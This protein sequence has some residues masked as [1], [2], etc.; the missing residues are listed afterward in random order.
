MVFNFGECFACRQ[1]YGVSTKIHLNFGVGFG[2]RV[3]CVSKSRANDAL[4]ISRLCVFY[5][6]R[7]RSAKY[8]T[9]H[10]K[11]PRCEINTN[12][13]VYF[14]QYTFV[15]AFT[16]TMNFIYSHFSLAFSFPLVRFLAL[17]LLL[18]LTATHTQ[19]HAAIQILLLLFFIIYINFDDDGLGQ[20]V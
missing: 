3:Y 1:F 9:S 16:N 20:N 6:V 5:L 11:V 17:C 8:F 2:R 7:T 18:S 14:C 13:F 19:T 4:I 15:V 12:R 10:T